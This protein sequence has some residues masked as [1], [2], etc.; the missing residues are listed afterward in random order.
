MNEISIIASS[1]LQENPVPRLLGELGTTVRFITLKK[2]DFLLSGKYGV[3]YMSYDIFA[4]SLKSRQFY[5]TI[6]EMKAEYQSPIMI[7]EGDVP[8]S[9]RIDATTYQNALLFASVTNRVPL[10]FTANEMETTHL[11][12]MLAGQ[13][14]HQLDP[15]EIISHEK[16]D[17]ASDAS[18]ARAVSHGKKGQNRSRLEILKMV[19]E[20]N[21]AS[22]QALIDRFKTLSQI[23]A[24]D[25]KNLQKVSG[26]GPKRALAIYQF[27]NRNG[28]Y[29]SPV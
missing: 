26:I 12:F 10:L 4:E 11:I 19:P 14:S 13:S 24:S 5:R 17:D 20:I 8:R 3:A 29:A 7:V 23:F 6:M 18:E 16:V 27:F 9:S 22:A 21:N 25:A 15:Q 2:G 1:H 28:N